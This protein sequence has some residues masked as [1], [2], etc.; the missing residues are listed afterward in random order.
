MAL[1][2]HAL[3]TVEQAK[4]QINNDDV[5]EVVVERLINAAS[6]AIRRYCGRDFALQTI[7]EQIVG[8]GSSRLMLQLTPVVAVAY[9]T[10]PNGQVHEGP[11]EIEDPDAGFVTMPGSIRIRTGEMR[12]GPLGMAAGISER[13]TLQVIYTGG[14]ITPAQLNLEPSLAQYY[15]NP[16]QVVENARTLP[17]DIEQ[18]CLQLVSA[19]HHERQRDPGVVS[20]KLGS[21]GIT[22]GVPTWMYPLLAPWKRVV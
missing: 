12:G 17:Y 7:T 20:E 2:K 11:C 9:I 10:G 6:D 22:Y 13:A 16:A 19:W 15:A 3:T 21:F 5:P 14:Y 18:A 1:S 8:Y 4:Y